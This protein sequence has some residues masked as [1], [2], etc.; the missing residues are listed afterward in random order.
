MLLR[1]GPRK[2]LSYRLAW[3][4]FQSHPVPFDFGVSYNQGS[5][6]ENTGF[7]YDNNVDVSIIKNMFIVEFNFR[8]SKGKAVKK[9]RK[10][11]QL[12]EENGGGG[13]F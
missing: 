10:E 7:V 4:F 6:I 5:R 2:R 1:S 8:L 11:H 9:T 12:E 13:I 3:V